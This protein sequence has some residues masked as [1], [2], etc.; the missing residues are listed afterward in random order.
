MLYEE[1]IAVA[2]LAQAVE[3]VSSYRKYLLSGKKITPRRKMEKATTSLQSLMW[4]ATPSRSG[5]LLGYFHTDPDTVITGIEEIE[6]TAIALL[7]WQIGELR[8]AAKDEDE[9]NALVTKYIFCTEGRTLAKY[10]RLTRQTVY[11]MAE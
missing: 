10:G 5:W 11:R 2:I 3:D 7:D 8:S 1:K 9:Y 6:K 4:L